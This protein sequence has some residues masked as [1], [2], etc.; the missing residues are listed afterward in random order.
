MDNTQSRKAF[1]PSELII[2][3]LASRSVLGKRPREPG[4][5]VLP[6]REALGAMYTP[7]GTADLPRQLICATIAHQSLNKVR[8][9]VNA[10]CWARDGRRAVTA[11]QNGEFTLWNGAAFNFEGLIA[12]HNSAVRSLAWS[13]SGTTILSGDA[14]GTIKY[15]ESS[16]TP[17]K[18]LLG[19]HGG[20]A[21]RGLKFAPS[22][23]KFCSCADD[24]TVRV[25]DWELFKEERILAGHGWDVKTCDWHPTYQL[26]ASGSKDNQVKMW[27]PRKR[28]CSAT[29]YGHKHTVMKVL[30][31]PIDPNWLLT[32]SRDHTL[33]LYDIRVLKGAETFKGHDRE[34][35]SCAWHPFNS[36]VFASG[37]YDGRVSHWLV[38]LDRPIH[39]HQAHEQAVWDLAFH[40]VGHVLATASNDHRV[41]FW[42]RTRPGDDPEAD[43]DDTQMALVRARA[44]AIGYEPPLPIEMEEEVS[45]ARFATTDR[46]RFGAPGRPPPPPMPGR[47]QASGFG[48]HAA[49]SYGPG[50][51]GGGQ[52]Y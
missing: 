13:R 2:R 49:T 14:K 45:E 43:L 50:A 42:C 52:R 27:D 24:G 33:K 16:M 46:T 31:N 41:K 39:S 8:F 7:K 44:D 19:T 25:W 11:N 15:W 18:E 37:A 10:L 20:N 34:V 22:D 6:V 5:V 4:E 3:E 21:V 32:A 36:R 17:V 40:P 29:L 12:A 26:I 38:G 30:W 1:D 51:G 28:S 35:T 23:A 9:P 47:E 48:Q